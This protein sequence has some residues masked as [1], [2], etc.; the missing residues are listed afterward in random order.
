MPPRQKSHRCPGCL[1]RLEELETRSLLNAGPVWSVVGTEEVDTIV[2]RRSP[3]HAGVLQAVVN[4]EVVSRHDQ[5]S[6]RL[7]R[8]VA[9]AG[10]DTVTFDLGNRAPGFAVRVMGGAGH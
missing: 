10:D 6:L 4:G 7:L 3:A 2:I 9:G 8:V 1:P 5:A